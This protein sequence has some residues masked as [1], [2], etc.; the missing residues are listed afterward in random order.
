MKEV[1]RNAGYDDGQREVY[2]S[3]RVTMDGFRKPS[4]S[5]KGKLALDG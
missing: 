3:T 5:E 4:N 2:V 1:E